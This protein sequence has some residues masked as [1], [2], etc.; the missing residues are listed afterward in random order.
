MVYGVTTT[1]Y[2]ITHASIFKVLTDMYNLD[3]AQI[4]NSVSGTINMS[5]AKTHVSSGPDIKAFDIFD[6]R[7][8]AR[9]HSSDL[10]TKL[11]NAAARYFSYHIENQHNTIA[12]LTKLIKSHGFKL[13]V[14]TH[15]IEVDDFAISR[16]VAMVDFSGIIKTPATIKS[17]IDSCVKLLTDAKLTVKA[18]CSGS[19]GLNTYTITTG[20]FNHITLLYICHNI[21]SNECTGYISINNILDQLSENK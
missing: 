1:E 15:D 16:P 5:S 13:D 12:E 3:S 6:L 9:K 19:N 18:D 17:C 20:Q 14:S 8:V 21:N 7:N 11:Y 10:A 4:T 2:P